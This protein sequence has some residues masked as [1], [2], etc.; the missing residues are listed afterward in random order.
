MNKANK[1]YWAN[2]SLKVNVKLGGV[3]QRVGNEKGWLP[4]KQ[5]NTLST[6]RL[7]EYFD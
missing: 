7:Q 4:G 5:L 3:N 2:V 6:L 1:Q